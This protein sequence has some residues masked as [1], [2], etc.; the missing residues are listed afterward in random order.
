MCL[1]GAYFYARHLKAPRSRLLASYLVIGWILVALGGPVSLSFMVPLMY[2]L[3]AMGI[4][5]LM[6]EWLAVFPKNPLARVTGITLISLLICFAAFY[7]LRSY[8]VSWPHNNTT[9]TTFVYRP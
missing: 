5:Y 7:N 9:M 3:A 8:F 1:I 4:A 6:H 2:V